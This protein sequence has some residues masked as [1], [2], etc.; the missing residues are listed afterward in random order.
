[1]F[2][3]YNFNTNINLKKIINNYKNYNYFYKSLKGLAL[4]KGDFTTLSSLFKILIAIF[5]FNIL[6]KN[7]AINRAKK[8]KIEVI[9]KNLTFKSRVFKNNSKYFEYSIEVAY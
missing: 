9:K 7:K 5:N 1:M 4:Y 8:N 6:L 2:N 3:P